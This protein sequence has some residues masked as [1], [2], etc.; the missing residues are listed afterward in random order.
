MTTE[1]TKPRIT[2]KTL[3][4]APDQEV[5]DQV[6]QHLRDQGLKSQNEN[7]CAYRGGDGGLMCAA[8]C[9]IADDE[10]VASTMDYA[11]DT[12]W[13]QLVIDHVVPEEHSI[14]IRRLQVV[15]DCYTDNRWEEGFSHTARVFGI[16]YTPPSNYK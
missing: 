4:Q 1:C 3:A 15:H 5:F 9:L 8:G 13:T 6:V 10:Y 2:L 16:A 12:T 14:L 11:D 7:G